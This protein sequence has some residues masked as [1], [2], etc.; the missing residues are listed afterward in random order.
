M[1]DK[2]TSVQEWKD[3]E[4]LPWKD[5]MAKYL[6]QRGQQMARLKQNAAE[7]QTIVAMLGEGRTKQAMMTWNTLG[8]QPK[9]KDL[10]VGGDGESLSLVATD[11]KVTVLMLDDLIADLQQLLEA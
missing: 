7:L 10:R 3:K 1:V 9:L 8:L 5:A 2:K 6:D 4:F 11:G